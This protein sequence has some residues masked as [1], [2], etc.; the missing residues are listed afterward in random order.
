MFPLFHVAGSRPAL[1]G[2]LAGTALFSSCA[3]S[4]LLQSTPS[5]AR[6]YLDG[7]AVGLTPYRHTDTKIVGTTTMVRL[8]KNGY[9]PLITSFSRNEEVDV[10]AIIGGL[11]VYV[12]F[13]WTMKYKPTHSYELQLP[14]GP[15]PLPTVGAAPPTLAA[16]P[17]PP[18]QSRADRLRENKKLLDEK[19]L[20]QQEYEKEKQRILTEPE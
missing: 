18:T 19:V 5:G 9:E 3:S 17:P 7:E 2:L 16:P 13:L 15:G 10:G 4:T 6:L 1:A 12:P 11:F 14:G 20:T 8:E